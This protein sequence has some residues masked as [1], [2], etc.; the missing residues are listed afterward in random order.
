SAGVSQAGRK[1]DLFIAQSVGRTV[2]PP[3]IDSFG[4]RFVGPAA[5]RHPVAILEGRLRYADV[6]EFVEV[7][8]L[9][10]PDFTGA[11]WRGHSDHQDGMRV[12][13]MVFLDYAFSTDG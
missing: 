13:E 11:G 2:E 1:P 4:I 7:V 5:G 6:D 12:R 8:H 10:A 9:K 3:E